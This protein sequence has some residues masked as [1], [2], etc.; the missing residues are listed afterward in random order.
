MAGKQEVR[1]LID[2][3]LELIRKLMGSTCFTKEE[4]DDVVN[5]LQEAVDELQKVVG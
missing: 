4:L 2:Q 3:L 1:G 5:K